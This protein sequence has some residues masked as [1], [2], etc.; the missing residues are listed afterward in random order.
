MSLN[1]KPADYLIIGAGIIISIIAGFIGDVF[2][3]LMEVEAYTR[4]LV[5]GSI[6]VALVFIYKA[7]A[8]WDG[9]LAR[10]LEIIGAGL[11]IL[12]LSWIPHIGWHLNGMNPMFGLSPSFWI[13]FF[14]VLTAIT[15]LIMGYGFYRFWKEG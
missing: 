7:R 3:V 1:L 11:T 6:I 5:G 15:F 4:F 13:S 9:Q 14:H 10:Y 8:A 12:M 2:N